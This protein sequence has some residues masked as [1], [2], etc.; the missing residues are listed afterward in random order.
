MIMNGLH[1]EF[2]AILGFIALSGAALYLQLQSGQNMLETWAESQGYK[3][4]KAEYAAFPM[5]GPYVWAGRNQAVYRIKVRLPDG[6]TRWGWVCCG[7]P[8]LG[9]AVNAV[10]ATWDKEVLPR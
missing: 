10:D 9:V 7:T 3:F 2:F 5:R 6:K 4:F 8:F 1:W